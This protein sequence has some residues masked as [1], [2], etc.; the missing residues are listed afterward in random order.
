MTTAVHTSTPAPTP[1]GGLRA[2][3]LIAAESAL[4]GGLT[5]ALGALGLALGLS[6]VFGPARHLHIGW[7]LPLV[8][9]SFDLDALGG[10]FIAVTGAVSIGVGVYAAGY[11]KREHW[12]RFPLVTLPLF[13]AA[14]LM[15]PAA[16]SVT[17]FLLAWELMAAAS[18]VLVLS[19]HRRDAA[20]YAGVF[21]A[22][23][24]QLGFVAIMV[25]L[26]VLSAAGGDDFKAIAEQS[27]HLSSGTRTAVFLLTLL[28]FGSK[29][30]LLPLHAWLPRA[31]PEAPSPVSALMSAA[32]VNMGIYG[33][34][35]IDLQLLG[36]GPHWMGLTLMIFG[37]VSA[38]F[39]VLQ[40]SVATDL[41]RLLAYSTTENMGLITLALGASALLSSSGAP[42]VAAI[43]MTAALLHL[44]SHAA[45][46]TL[47]FLAAGSVLSATGLRDLDKLGGLARRMPVTTVLFGIAALGA[48]G[49]PLG[50]GFVSEWLLLQSL[51]HSPHGANTLLALAMPLSVGVVA[52]TCGLGIAA[53]V[54]AFGVGFLAR[55]RSAAAEAAREAPASMLVGM[56]LAAAAC[57]VFAVAPALLGPALDKVLAVLPTLGGQGAGPRLS[58]ILRLPG[59][60]GSISP[61]ALAL[62]LFVAVA[63]ALGIA[64]WGGRHRPAATMAPLWACGADTLGPRMQYTATSFAEP[65][66]R[67]F[68]DVLRPDTDVE[69][70]HFAESLYLV[71][72]VTYRTRLDDPVEQRF[73]TPVVLAVTTWAGWVRRAH[74]GSIHL[75]LTYGALWMLV[76]LLVAR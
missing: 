58:T 39:G 75:Y 20:R 26:V 69:V 40:A 21:Y 37:A 66:Q 50:A 68:D 51:I 24:T 47:G 33:I 7:L 12:A 43:A 61:G 22:I 9:V 13:V 70:T 41:K 32:M 76:V 63:F 74:N 56:T 65:L 5:A 16:G 71:E 53:M 28:G 59:I 1:G 31:H 6:A 25:A 35:R 2:T 45:F 23:M 15:V 46:K 60:A 11:A 30:G 18:L 14:L 4:S 72:K 34:I 44:M 49:L 73:Y 52:L 38:V 48:S 57:A 3:R 8:G 55:P 54:K 64:R 42:T 10:L 67:V 27:D 17:T 29:A 62:S 36:P 19:E